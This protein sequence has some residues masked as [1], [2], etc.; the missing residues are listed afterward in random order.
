VSL[1]PVGA[2]KPCMVT[3]VGNEAFLHSHAAGGAF[4]SWRTHRGPFPAAP[5]PPERSL[6]AARPL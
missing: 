2:A 1:H 3:G 6:R 4:R 5:P